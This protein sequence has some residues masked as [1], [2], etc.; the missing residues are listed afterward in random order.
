[1]VITMIVDEETKGLRTYNIREMNPVQHPHYPQDDTH[2]HK[3]QINTKQNEDISDDISTNNN[4]LIESLPSSED[5]NEYPS[6]NTI[7]GYYDRSSENP[8]SFTSSSQPMA[9]NTSC[10]FCGAI[11]KQNETFCN[12]CGK[13]I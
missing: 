12:N 7:T 6:E 5:M 4:L 2:P 13:R 9:S 1:M 10:P 8:G 11:I 3:I